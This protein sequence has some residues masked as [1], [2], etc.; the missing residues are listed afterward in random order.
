MDSLA[1]EIALESA[2][3][4][5]IGPFDPPPS[6]LKRVAGEADSDPESPNGE[7]S[8]SKAG[9][10]QLRRQPSNLSTTDA[11]SGLL[12][13]I[14]F[15]SSEGLNTFASQSLIESSKGS[16][17]S[18]TNVLLQSISFGQR[19][20]PQLPALD[21]R[22][23]H[24]SPHHGSSSSGGVRK[25]GTRAFRNLRSLIDRKPKSEEIP[26]KI[27]LFRQRRSPGS[28]RKD[29]WRSKSLLS[30]PTKSEVRC[31]PSLFTVDPSLLCQTKGMMCSS[32]S[33]W[34][35]FETRI[36]CAPS[37]NNYALLESDQTNDHPRSTTVSYRDVC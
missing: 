31:P 28:D 23:H 30:F 37:F 22:T 36:P 33:V 27:P 1:D 26:S 8:T 18:W 5:T 14:E 6:R 11:D 7:A 24:S 17:E 21:S 9:Y 15:A 35:H 20:V 10:V 19:E 13:S 2:R 3:S 32:S 16:Q 34:S 29:D 25:R 12:S 4:I